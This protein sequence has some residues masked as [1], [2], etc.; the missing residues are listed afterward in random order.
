MLYVY[1]IKKM[2]MDWFGYDGIFHEDI[3]QLRIGTSLA[4]TWINQL[5]LRI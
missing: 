1:M 5:L 4:L 2:L 3:H